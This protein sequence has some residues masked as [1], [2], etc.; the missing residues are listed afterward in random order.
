MSPVPLISFTCNICGA[1]NTLEEVPWEPPTCSGCNSNVRMRALI[2]LLSIELY[3]KPRPL[4]EFPRNKNIKGFGLTDDLL[5]ATPLANTFDYTNTFYDREPYLDL[6]EPHPEQYGTYDF[7]L[8]SDVF[9]HV[10]PP[11]ERAFEEACQLLKPNGFLCITV[12]STAA[13]EDT[14]EYYPELHEY[15]IVELGGE[16]ILVNR[17]R[18]KTLAV[19][20]DL[21]FHGGV[22]ATLVMRLFSQRDLARKL[23]G[24]GFSEVVYQ[25][26]S[27]ETHG[28]VM[29]GQWSLPL[30]ARKERYSPPP[31]EPEKP[32]PE[33]EADILPADNPAL[34]TAESQV[35]EEKA[36]L[37]RK[38]VELESKLHLAAD[39]RWLKLGRLFGLGPKLR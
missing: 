21:E 5:Y 33:R 11:V 7:I 38:V 29:A 36:E 30:V 20:R 3:G 10:A 23:Q 13:D 31:A 12:P 17:K 9:E 16:H 22:G 28:I 6:T 25:T 15:S 34:D 18:D 4:S 37:E 24:C 27:V 8:S 26:A 14:V 1:A 2:H 39:S 32:E 19:H 35:D